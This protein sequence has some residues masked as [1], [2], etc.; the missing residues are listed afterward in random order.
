MPARERVAVVVL[1]VE[2][3]ENGVW[4]DR[5]EVLSGGLVETEAGELWSDSCLGLYSYIHID[6]IQRE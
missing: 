2:G 4:W 3:S 1:R 6:Y 5:R